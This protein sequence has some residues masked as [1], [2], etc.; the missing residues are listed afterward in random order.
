MTWTQNYDPLGSPLLS[1]LVAALPILLLLGLLASGRASAPVAALVGLLAAFFTAVLVF[2]PV[3]ANGVFV[4]LSPKIFSALEARGWHFYKFVGEHGY[5]LMCSWETR[6]EEVTSFL[7]DA[8]AA[9]Q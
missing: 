5:R 8:K 4:E 2:A 6:D 9:K 3:E 1:S 7:A